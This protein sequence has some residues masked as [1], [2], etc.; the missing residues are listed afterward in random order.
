MNNYSIPQSER[1]INPNRVNTTKFIR[2]FSNDPRNNSTFLREN[3]FTIV[4]NAIS[5]VGGSDDLYI[6]DPFFPEQPS[7]PSDPDPNVDNPDIS[8]L[9]APVNLAVKN[10]E[11]KLGTDG[12]AYYIATITLDDVPGAE[13]YEAV[14]EIVSWKVIM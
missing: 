6:G 3:P 10:F 4:V 2:I 5:D 8:N 12:T 13:E 1:Y 7:T 11:L 14:L 9:S